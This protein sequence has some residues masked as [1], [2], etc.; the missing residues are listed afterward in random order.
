MTTR[1][2][3]GVVLIVIGGIASLVCGMGLIDPVGAKLADDSDPFGA[4]SSWHS[5]AIGLSVSLAVA[6]V[7]AWLALLR[8]PTSGAGGNRHA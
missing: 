4:P 7:G 3:L 2:A 8:K 6:G 5:G 1:R